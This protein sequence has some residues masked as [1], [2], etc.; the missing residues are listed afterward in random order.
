MRRELSA[1]RIM[2]GDRKHGAILKMLVLD[3]LAP[4]VVVSASRNAQ[5]VIFTISIP[6]A[7]EFVPL[8]A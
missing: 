5:T 1:A 2:F 4:T 7:A 3:A 6:Q 8:S